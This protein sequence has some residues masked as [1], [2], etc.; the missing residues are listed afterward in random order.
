MAG[1][2]QL[3]SR[4]VKWSFCQPLRGFSLISTALCFTLYIYIYTGSQA[5]IFWKS[6]WG[7][8]H[9]CGGLG[10]G[11]CLDCLVRGEETPCHLLLPQSLCG[12][13]TVSTPAS[14]PASSPVTTSPYSMARS[15]SSSGCERKSPKIGGG[16]SFKESGN[17]KNFCPVG[18]EIKLFEFYFYGPF[19]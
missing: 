13:A 4:N 1:Y 7:H 10:S 15:R 3:G 17:W 2:N 11:V 14:F 16:G 8:D 19:L 9:H 6:Y 12:S 5:E 18:E